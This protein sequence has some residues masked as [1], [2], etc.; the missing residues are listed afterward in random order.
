MRGDKPPLPYRV[1]AIGL[2]PSDR[3]ILHQRIAHR[4]DTMLKHGL[5]DEVRADE[6]R[7]LDYFGVTK[8]EDLPASQYDRVV[9]SLERGRRKAA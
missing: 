3:K 9:R 2:E 6:P 5:I 8:I 1:I 4:F 7:L